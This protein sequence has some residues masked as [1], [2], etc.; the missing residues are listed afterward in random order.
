MESDRVP[1]GSPPPTWDTFVRSLAPGLCNLRLFRAVQSHV[2]FIGHGRSGSSLVGSLLNAHRHALIAHELNELHF[3]KRKFT[4]TQLNWLLYAQDRAFERA[5][6]DWTG[7]NYR[8]EGQWQGRFEKIFVVGD[9]HAGGATRLLGQRPEL[10][11]RLRR[12]VGVPVKMIH[13]VR[14]P[15]DNISTL[16][17]RQNLS[18]EAAAR[19][20]FE[21]AATNH[22]L[23]RENPADVLTVHLED[24]IARPRPELSRLCKFLDLD[25]PAD[26]LDDCASALFAEPRQTRDLVEWPRDLVAD[27]LRQCRDL[28]FLH[29]Y[30]PDIVCFGQSPG[31]VQS[32]RVDAPPVRRAA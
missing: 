28:P 20:Y 21:H 9:K 29:R 10:L 7:Y 11:D 12:T 3:I 22:R 16:H 2:L 1:H 5:G 13:L 24:V 27:I 15:L 26:Y 14:N 18:L 8:V 32:S 19:L 23:I 6:R 31:P 4:G 17:R 25:T 30:R